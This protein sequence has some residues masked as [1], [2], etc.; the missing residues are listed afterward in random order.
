MVA[1]RGH[2]KFTRRPNQNL[3]TLLQ[4]GKE[5]N[6]LE[7][8]KKIYGSLEFDRSNDGR[9]EGYKS[10]IANQP[11]F[12][13]HVYN[14]LAKILLD[15]QYTQ[16]WTGSI[17]PLRLLQ[18][19]EEWPELEITMDKIATPPN[20]Q[21]SHR[22]S[23]LPGASTAI[24]HSTRHGLSTRDGLSPRDGLSTGDGLPLGDG[25]HRCTYYLD[26]RTVVDRPEIRQIDFHSGLE[27]ST[28][29]GIFPYLTIGFTTTRNYNTDTQDRMD[30]FRFG[31]KALWSQLQLRLNAM[32]KRGEAVEALSLDDIGHFVCIVGMNGWAIYRLV[33]GQPPDSTSKSP[34]AWEVDCTMVYEV[35]G[36]T[37]GLVDNLR[38]VHY[39]G[40]QSF[41][42]AVKL[43]LATLYGSMDDSSDE[44]NRF[45]NGGTLPENVWQ[46]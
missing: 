13:A 30:A 45:G 24:K 41:G 40:L 20:A 26:Q 22:N 44:G 37:A 19:N 10:A 34:R 42:K 46:E 27:W 21:S 2:I 28:P 39:W 38:Y 12:F 7:D 6:I 11:T 43:D 25:L 9:E 23:K 36:A 32:K 3:G 14:M 35:K 33:A 18:P 29:N 16:G 17:L 1:Q 31:A 8:W 4:L 15:P 5:D